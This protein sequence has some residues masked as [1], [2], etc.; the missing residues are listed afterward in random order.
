MQ[1]SKSYIEIKDILPQ[2]LELAQNPN[3]SKAK[4]L[5]S[6]AYQKSLENFYAVEHPEISDDDYY[7]EASKRAH[8]VERRVFEI[9]LNREK[10]M[11]RVWQKYEAQNGP[12]SE[13]VKRLSEAALS[14]GLDKV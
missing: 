7:A 13:P 10:P 14:L 1:T 11:A 2:V 4:R 6:E 3:Y 5:S 12:I 8:A 9:E